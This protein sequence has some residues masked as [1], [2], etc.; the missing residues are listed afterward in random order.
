VQSYPTLFSLE[1]EVGARGFKK[2]L[3]GTMLSDFNAI[4]N[5]FKKFLD[6][7]YNL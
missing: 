3:I 2:I 6:Y 5:V 7:I 1:K 4:L